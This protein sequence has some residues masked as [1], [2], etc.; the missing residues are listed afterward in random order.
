MDYAEFH[1][2]SIEDRDGEG[3]PRVRL[4]PVLLPGAPREPVLPL[5]LRGLHMVDLRVD[6]EG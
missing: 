3:R 5:F 6:C 1:R 2:R 4:V